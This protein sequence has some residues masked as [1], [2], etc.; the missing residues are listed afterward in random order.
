MQKRAANGAF[1]HFYF[2]NFFRMSC[3]AAPTTMLRNTNR[4]ILDISNDIGIT[5]LS[6]FNHIF[7]EKYG[8]SPNRYRKERF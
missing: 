7:K 4:L 3:A 6:H 1:L 8:I 2:A 5:S